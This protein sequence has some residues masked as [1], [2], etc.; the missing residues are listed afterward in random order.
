[1]LSKPAAEKGSD[2]SESSDGYGNGTDRLGWFWGGEEDDVFDN[3]YASGCAWVAWGL[4]YTFT[5]IICE[6]VFVSMAVDKLNGVQP[7]LFVS[8]SETYSM[9]E[10]DKC[11]QCRIEYEYCQKLI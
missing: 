11:L 9:D 1:M 4:W 8:Q 10:L 7:V 6:I 2:V 3:G 5:N